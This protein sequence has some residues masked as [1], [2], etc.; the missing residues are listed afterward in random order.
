MDPRDQIKSK[1]DIVSFIES[2]IPLKK[3]GRNF[4]ALCPFHGEKSPSFVI[5]PERQ[6]WHCFGCQK[7]GDIFTF[8]M[9][10]ERIDFSE[11]LRLLAQQAG[12]KL[13]NTSL[14]KQEEGKE[15]LYAINHLASEFYH[16]L[17]K[18]HPSGQKAYD[19]L[20]Q[21]GIS[22]KAMETFKL[23]V[24]PNQWD[25][26]FNYLTRKKGFLKDDLV[27]A[28]VAAKSQKGN[29]FD[30]FRNRIMFTLSDH[31]GNNVGFAGR[32][33]TEDPVEREAKYINTSETLIYHKG[34]TLYG[35]HI[36]KEAVK[37]SGSIVLV[38][39]EI[40]AIQS[41]QAGV[42][43]VAAIKGT[44]LTEMQIK[45]LKRFCDTV[46]LA[47]DFDVAGDAAVRRGI[48]L[49]DKEGMTI[50][51]VQAEG[52]KDP[53]EVIRNNP[54]LWKEAIKNAV[55]VYDFII[56]SAA[57]RFDT[58]TIDGKKAF[59]DD[60]LPFLA[61]ITNEVVKAHYIKR[62][63]QLLDVS[64][65]VVLRQMKKQT[66]VARTPALEKEVKIPSK[67]SRHERI[68]EYFVALCLQKGA[69][70]VIKEVGSLVQK[71]WFINNAFWRVFEALVAFY[72]NE[73]SF[74]IET[75]SKTLPAE[76][77]PTSDT[78]Y[79]ID[80]DSVDSIFALHEIRRLAIELEI[81]F[82]KSRMQT[83]SKSI[84]KEEQEGNI[85]RTEALQFEFNMLSN[86]LSEVS[87]REQKGVLS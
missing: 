43:N 36:T 39:G 61:S 9:E 76:V 79:L 53:D 81:L 67:Q 83:I 48:I 22:D 86:R 32:V 80:L 78:L 42:G 29:Y 68:E 56:D 37:R 20:K 72:T 35:L 45:L 25:A 55:N 70:E 17:L 59:T 84:A 77:F 52:G 12:V 44:A 23:G 50:K 1:I 7:G 71:E 31:R 75:F 27:E 11:A 21:R 62:A 18:T 47:L 85:E 6:I 49:A 13:E 15:R 74:S 87:R 10:Y 2:Y 19:Y 41:F 8:M 33:Y 24:A 46:I 4:K 14:T 16:Y 69:K 28:G 65:D 64:E 51:V 5:S 34:E 54:I 38:E 26:L 66:V 73:D 57:A 30:R 63:S 60:V 82:I 58:A 3:A 40:D